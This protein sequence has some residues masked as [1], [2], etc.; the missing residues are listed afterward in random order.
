MSEPTYRI[1]TEHTPDGRYPNIPWQARIVRLSDGEAIKTCWGAN[2]AKAI[3]SATEHI[4]AINVEV[5]EGH[6]Y[7]ANEDGTLAAE[8]PAPEPQSLRA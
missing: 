3:E 6:V 1:T 2:E 5:Q 7:F 8:T 4:A